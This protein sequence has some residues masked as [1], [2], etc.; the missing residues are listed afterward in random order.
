M[1]RNVSQ[2]KHGKRRI[3]SSARELGNDESGWIH[4]DSIFLY[5]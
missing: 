3:N 2:V 1:D 4:S 5:R